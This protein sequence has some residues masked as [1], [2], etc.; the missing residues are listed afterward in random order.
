M[1]LFVEC[2]KDLINLKRVR[3][4]YGAAVCKDNFP[5]VFFWL[6]A[7][8]EKV[9]IVDCKEVGEQFVI[10]TLC[11]GMAQLSNAES[12]YCP[13]NVFQLFLLFFFIDEV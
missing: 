8:I 1:D 9:L 12:H 4:Q 13:F 3:D 6:C 2:C 7:H 11:L 10:G 5:F